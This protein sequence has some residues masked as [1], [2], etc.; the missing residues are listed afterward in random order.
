MVATY[1]TV[2]EL[3]GVEEIILPDM[4]VKFKD[5]AA[6]IRFAFVICSWIC[7][8]FHNFIGSL[9]ALS[10]YSQ[11][12]GLINSVDLQSLLWHFVLTNEICSRASVRGDI[13]AVGLLS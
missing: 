13:F 7:D 11:F 12:H 6:G 3:A 4:W 1:P 10:F 2:L 8:V 9:S 5:F